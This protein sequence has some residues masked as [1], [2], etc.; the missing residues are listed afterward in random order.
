MNTGDGYKRGKTPKLGAVICWRKGK[1][2]YAADGAGHVAF[3]EKINADGSIVVSNSNYSGTRFFTR[4][5]KGPKWEIGTGLTFQGFIY[6]PVDF[7]LAKPKSSFKISDADYPVKIKKGNYFTITGTIQSALKM[8]K[9]QV[10]V[11]DKKSKVVYR[12]TAAPNTKTWNIHKAD[13]AMMFRKLA[14]GEYTYKIMAWDPNGIHTLLNKT[15]K[16]I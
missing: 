10:M 8:S 3:V 1:A 6:A 16:V 13:N 14:K 5:I 7:V 15:F 9:V 4:T 12:F 11:L 2:G